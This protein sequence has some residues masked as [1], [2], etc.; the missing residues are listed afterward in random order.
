MSA[1]IETGVTAGDLGGGVHEDG[2]RIVQAIDICLQAAAVKGSEIQSVV[3]TGGSTAIAEV[4]RL[5]L[6]RLPN[7][8]PVKGDM[9]GSVGLG[10]AI[11]A[12]RRFG[13]SGH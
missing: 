8:R 11:D 4:R 12:E 1:P 7:A 6:Q 3:L 9:F 13:G 10:L 2:L 5:I